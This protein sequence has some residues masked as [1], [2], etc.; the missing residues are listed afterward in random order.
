MDLRGGGVLE[1]PVERLPASSTVT[2]CRSRCL[3]VMQFVGGDGDCHQCAHTRP[4]LPT[5]CLGERKNIAQS[6][7]SRQLY[8][9]IKPVFVPRGT[10]RTHERTSA[11]H[12]HDILQVPNASPFRD[13]FPRG[14]PQLPLSEQENVRRLVVSC[15]CSFPNCFTSDSRPRNEYITRFGHSGQDEWKLRSGRKWEIVHETTLLL[16]NLRNRRFPLRSTVHGYGNWTRCLI[17]YTASPGRAVENH[18]TPAEMRGR[19]PGGR[20]TS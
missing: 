7:R 6:W 1:T 9:I 10:A 11:P 5:V 2:H 20:K 8:V 4:Y 16:Q 15:P 14:N 18:D 3:P 12:P 17:S 13:H 19:K